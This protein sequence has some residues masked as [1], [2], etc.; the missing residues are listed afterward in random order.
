MTKNFNKKNLTI[1]IEDIDEIVDE[2]Q[3]NRQKILNEIEL[4][5]N[6]CYSYSN[7][8]QNQ[9]ILRNNLL[10]KNNMYL[11]QLLFYMDGENYLSDLS[12]YKIIKNDDIQNISKSIFIKNYCDINNNFLLNEQKIKSEFNLLKLITETPNH[13]NLQIDILKTLKRYNNRYSDI[14]PYNYNS[15]KYQT[16]VTNNYDKSNQNDWY[17]NASFINGPFKSDKNSFIAAQTPVLNT[18]GKFYK[19]CFNNNIK[20]LIMLCCFEEE[21]RKKCE[22]YLPNQI[23]EE[24]SFD[25]NSVRVKITNEEFLIKNCLIKREISITIDNQTKNIYHLQMLNWPDYSKP[26]G[27]LGFNTVNYLINIMAQSREIFP[28]SPILI[29]CSA[30]TGRTGTL[31]AIFNLIK[32]ISFFQTVNNDNSISPFFSVFNMVR[33]LREQRSGMVA[34]FEQ[35]K[36]IYHFL[37]NW[38]QRNI[39]HS[40]SNK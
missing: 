10:S 20:I 18:I 34:C 36:F 26:E 8:I 23:N 2:E 14:L 4:L 1:C 17:I 16:N 22:Y 21:G 38:I 12:Y 13:K 27:E 35:Y 33:R 3:I 30:G 7:Y 11:N 25:N 39:L 32:C 40:D 19:M 24:I 28:D 9:T 6:S 31:I 29:H 5:K 37:F 15:V